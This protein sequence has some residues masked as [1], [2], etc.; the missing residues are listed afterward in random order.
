[1]KNCPIRIESGKGYY[2]DFFI[3]NEIAVYPKWL[4]VLFLNVGSLISNSR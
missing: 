4:I 1:M 2:V 3:L